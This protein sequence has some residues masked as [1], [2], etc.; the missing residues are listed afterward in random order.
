MNRAEKTTYVQELE[1]ELET[2]RVYELMERLTRELIVHQPDNP[3]DFLIDRLKNPAG[4]LG[5]MQEREYL[6]WARRGLVLGSSL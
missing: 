2:K 5:F 6:S 4:L 3:I 1:K